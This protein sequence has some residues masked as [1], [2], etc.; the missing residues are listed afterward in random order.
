MRRVPAL[1]LLAGMLPGPACA[2]LPG[3]SPLVASYRTTVN[4]VPAG[5][6]AKVEI[7]AIGGTRYEANFHIQNRFFRHEEVSRFDWQD[8]KVTAREYRHEFAGLGIERD[9]AVVFDWPRMLAI[10]TRGETLREIRLTPDIA[11][12]LNM[13]MLARCR[14]RNGERALDFPIIYRGERKELHFVVTGREVVE[15]ALGNFDSLVIERRYPNSRFKRTRVWVAPALDWFM[16]RFEH[17]EN[18][19]ARGSMLITG[20]SQE[21]KLLPAP[22]ARQP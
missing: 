22:P 11:D 16:V 12:G 7:R 8:C 9:S 1:L 15:T 4:G 14:L 6:P 21:G 2:E 3:L 13:A 17:V 10:E 20:F 19:A 5:T 18:P